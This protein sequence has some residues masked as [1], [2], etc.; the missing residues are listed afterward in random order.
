MK[1]FFALVLF[2]LVILGSTPASGQ[3]IETPTDPPP[4]MKDL[5]LPTVFDTI[6]GNSFIDEASGDGANGFIKDEAAAI[7]ARQGAVL[8]H[9]DG[10]RRGRLRDLSLSCRRRQPA[11]Q[12]AEPGLNGGNGVSIRRDR[13]RRPELQAAAGDFPFHELAIRP[14][15]F[16]RAV[17]HRRRGVVAGTFA[18]TSTTIVPGEADRRLHAV[19][20]DPFGF[21]INGI[22]TRRSSRATRRR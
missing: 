16:G 1:S 14:T 17:R 5:A 11:A 19:I 12:P 15:G 2:A 21:Q 8:G 7:A 20:P 6:S 3:F 22:N 9:A 18:A 10:Q 4:S 13:Q